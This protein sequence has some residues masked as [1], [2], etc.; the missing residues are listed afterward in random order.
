MYK[1][2]KTSVLPR[3]FIALFGTSLQLDF[4]HSLVVLRSDSRLK[5]DFFFIE[6]F[7]WNFWFRWHAGCP[8]GLRR[9]WWPR[10]KG[11]ERG[12]KEP[13]VRRRGEVCQV[14]V[15]ERGG[16]RVGIGVHARSDRSVREARDG[17]WWWWLIYDHSFYCRKYHAWEYGNVCFSQYHT[18]ILI[19]CEPENRKIFF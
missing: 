8:L 5:Q 15:K 7:K 6:C 10:V 3:L 17:L 16:R 14:G 19:M 2:G 13:E 4:F 12:A 11:M 9:L 18:V 1:W